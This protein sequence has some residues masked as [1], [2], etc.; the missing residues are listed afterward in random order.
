MEKF[1]WLHPDH[2]LAVRCLVVAYGR[3]TTWDILPLEQGMTLYFV[4]DGEPHRAGRRALMELV[5]RLTVLAE[6]G[7]YDCPRF[8]ERPLRQLGWNVV[9]LLAIALKRDRQRS[10]G[11]HPLSPRQSLEDWETQKWGDEPLLDLAEVLEE[12]QRLYGEDITAHVALVE[13][14]K[15]LAERAERRCKNIARREE[16]ER[17][18]AARQHERE[19]LLRVVSSRAEA[20][21]AVSQVV[22]DAVNTST[23]ASKL[24]LVS[25]PNPS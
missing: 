11:I 8:G 21:G 6:D 15:S 12:V 13:I 23:G 4:L 9:G 25:N 16:E 1:P 10:E 7:V 19:K 3:A 20:A 5:G 22:A 17:E 14:R 24:V 18:A 2:V